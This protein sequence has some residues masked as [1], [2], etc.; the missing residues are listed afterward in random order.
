MLKLAEVNVMQS[1][2]GVR[3]MSGEFERRKLANPTPTKTNLPVFV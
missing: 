2:D 1:N 3:E